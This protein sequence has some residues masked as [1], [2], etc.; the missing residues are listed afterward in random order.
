[1][2]WQQQQLPHSSS[3]QAAACANRQC[4]LCSLQQQQRLPLPRVCSVVARL[5]G[6]SLLAAVLQPGCVMWLVFMLGVERCP[7]FER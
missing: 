5:L 3:K 7:V 2:S 4:V 6:S 1:M